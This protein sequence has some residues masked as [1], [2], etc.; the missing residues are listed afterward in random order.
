M[1][2]E[3]GNLG[4]LPTSGTE[5]AF[6]KKLD[7]ALTVT[8]GGRRMISENPVHIDKIDGFSKA[9]AVFIVKIQEETDITVTLRGKRC[10]T[11]KE[12]IHL[13]GGIIDHVS[14]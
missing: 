5:N 2:V 3:I 11:A 12:V 9:R 6:R 14:P 1:T 8:L 13:K 10:G 4:F 7:C